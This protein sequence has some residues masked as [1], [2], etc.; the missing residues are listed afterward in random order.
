MTAEHFH[1]EDEAATRRL[2]CVLADA[3]RAIPLAEQGFAIHLSGDLG[4]GKTTL[5]RHLLA[6]LGIPGP[7]KSPSYALLEPYNGPSF[8][9]Y[10]FDLYR[11]SSPD[12][13]ADAG[14]DE[15][16]AG[17]GLQ[18]VEWPEQA[19]GALPPPDLGITLTVPGD[20]P[21]AD[22]PDGS[23]EGRRLAVAQAATAAGRRCLSAVKHAWSPGDTG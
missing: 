22:L 4:A 2:A 16:I 5:V 15:I 11:F 7:V 1:L 6:A 20:G 8:G 10:H 13:W 12:Q 17:P 19:A 23:V 21:P 14:F 18:V 9:V 3:L